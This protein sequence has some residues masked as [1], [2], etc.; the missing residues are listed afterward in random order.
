MKRNHI[1][2]GACSFACWVIGNEWRIKNGLEP[3][4]PNGTR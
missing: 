3:V 1:L 2:A 4:Y